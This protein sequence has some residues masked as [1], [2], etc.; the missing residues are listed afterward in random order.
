MIYAQ[1]NDNNICVSFSQLYGDEKGENMILLQ[2]HDPS[3][4]GKKYEKG[5]WLKV[6][7]EPEQP[8]PTEQEIVNADI[9]LNQAE[10]TAKLKAVDVD[11]R[12]EGQVVIPTIIFTNNEDNSQ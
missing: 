8:E 7:K 4:L 5:K 11:I 2:N 3:I 10:Q 9:L 12:A 1:L 6:P